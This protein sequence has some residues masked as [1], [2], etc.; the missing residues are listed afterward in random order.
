M[1]SDVQILSASASSLWLNRLSL[2]VPTRACRIA[3]TEDGVL[4]GATIACAALLTAADAAATQQE[5]MQ[6]SLAIQWSLTAL[7]EP[8]DLD[9]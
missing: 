9:L 4:F 5:G 2:A 3:Q 7:V 1:P 8:G 6:S